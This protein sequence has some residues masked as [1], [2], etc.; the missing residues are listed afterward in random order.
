MSQQSRH[1]TVWAVDFGRGQHRDLTWSPGRCR[2]Q[3]LQGSESVRVINSNPPAVP[4]QTDLVHRSIHLPVHRNRP[5]QAE[6][7]GLSLCSDRLDVLLDTHPDGRGGFSNRGSLL[8]EAVQ[9]FRV[10]ASARSGQVD[11]GPQSVVPATGVTGARV[12][13]HR[14]RPHVIISPG[15]QCAVPVFGDPVGPLPTGFDEA[16]AGLGAGPLGHE[17]WTSFTNASAAPRTSRVRCCWMY[18]TGKF[19]SSPGFAPISHANATLL[20][21][22]IS[23]VFH[24]R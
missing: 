12:E 20:P 5:R 6:P 18:S 4:G 16:Q 2:G 17:T 15:R 19:S 1:V 24:T 10:R 13:T 9:H 8:P 14:Q 22:A 7:V 23:R 3:T 11:G 21:S